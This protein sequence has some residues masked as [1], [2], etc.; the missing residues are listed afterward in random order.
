MWLYSILNNIT[1]KYVGRR[2]GTEVGLGAASLRHQQSLEQKDNRGDGGW[3]RLVYVC[4]PQDS[5]GIGKRLEEGKEG[6]S[7]AGGV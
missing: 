4:T 6:K 1:Q 7:I 3:K 2:G 5:P